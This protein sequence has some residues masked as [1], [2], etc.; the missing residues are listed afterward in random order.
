MIRTARIKMRI[1][2][3]AG[4]RLSKETPDKPPIWNECV[5]NR[6]SGN[7]VVI[8]FVP[9]E[10]RLEMATPDNIN[11]IL[12][13]PALSEI[14]LTIITAES[15]PENE[16][17]GISECIALEGATLPSE[18]LQSAAPKPAPAFTPIVPGL[19][20]GLAR[21]SWIT[22]PETAR[23]DPANTAAK[24]RGRRT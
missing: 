2:H 19:A 21:T 12:E 20:K 10:R 7:R 1:S 17:K 18:A 4:N 11:V 22:A 3:P 15:A 13:E 8:K 14:E 23:A 5:L 6:E 24:T 16:A 9:A